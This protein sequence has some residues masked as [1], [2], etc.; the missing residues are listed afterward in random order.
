MELSQCQAAGHG[1][2]ENRELAFEFL[3]EMMKPENYYTYITSESNLP[4][5]DMSEYPDV[6]SKPFMETAE[7]FLDNALFR[8]KSEVYSSVS[9]YIA[10][11]SEDAATS[12]DAEGAMNT[13]KDNVISVVGEEN[14]IEH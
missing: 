4:T 13:Y 14:T 7:S 9:T 11:M 8:P 5:I 3:T 6:L 12:M 2:S 10:Q 1:L